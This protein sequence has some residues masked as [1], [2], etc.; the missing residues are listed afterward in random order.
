MQETQ[1]G[2]YTKNRAAKDHCEEVEVVHHALLEFGVGLRSWTNCLMGH[3][4]VGVV[5]TAISNGFEFRISAKGGAT[6]RSNWGLWVMRGAAWPSIAHP[7]HDDG[8]SFPAQSGVA[9]RLPHALQDA[10]ATALGDEPR[11]AS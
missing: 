6:G 11:E 10:A 1:Q 2:D 4:S 5:K 8:R 3:N 7:T 9:L